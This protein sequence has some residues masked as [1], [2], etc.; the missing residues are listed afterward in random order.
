[1]SKIWKLD[2]LK[3]DLFE[4]GFVIVDPCCSIKYNAY[5]ANVWSLKTTFGGYLLSQCATKWFVWKQ[6]CAS[7]STVLVSWFLSTK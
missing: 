5:I 7:T 3:K 6:A 2:L 4:K 1:M